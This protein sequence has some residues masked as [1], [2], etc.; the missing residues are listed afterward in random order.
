MRLLRRIARRVGVEASRRLFTKT[1]RAGLKQ[2]IVSFSFDDF[3]H[4]AVTNG[5]RIL[6]SLGVC[7]SFYASGSL[8]GTTVDGMRQFEA[9]DILRLAEA[10]HEIGCHTFSHRAVPCMTAEALFHDIDRNASFI[11]KHLPGYAMCTFAYPFGEVSPLSKR[12]LR[13]QFAACRSI[14][15]GLNKSRVDLAYLKATSLSEERFDENTISRLVEQTVSSQAWLIFFCHEVDS[16]HSRFGCTP[17]FLEHAVTT[18]LRAGAQVIPVKNAIG[19]LR[20]GGG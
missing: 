19:A 2:S 8:C 18:A 20:V 6:E 10:G 3:P 13:R 7:G 1:I 17:R 9:E 14:Y 12:R 4:S 5:A 11:E 15:G 16:P